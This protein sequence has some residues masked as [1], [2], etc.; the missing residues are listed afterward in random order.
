MDSHSLYGPDA[1]YGYKYG[2]AI[3]EDEFADEEVDKVQTAVCSGINK[4]DFPVHI[5]LPPVSERRLEQ[6]KF[7]DFGHV[8]AI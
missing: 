2:P 1:R 6:Q 4:R 7:D 3:D 5:S 8:R